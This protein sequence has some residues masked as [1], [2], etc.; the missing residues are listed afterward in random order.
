MRKQLLFPL[1]SLVLLTLAA[2]CV[3]QVADLNP[4]F[5]PVQNTVNAKFVIN[6]AAADQPATKMSAAVVQ[7]NATF[8]GIENATLFTF[9]LRDGDTFRNGE[10]I[11]SASDTATGAFNLSKAFDISAFGEGGAK[12]HKVMELPIPVGTNTMIFYGMAA[13]NGMTDEQVGKTS[14]FYNTT[15]GKIGSFAEPR[16]RP[17]SD[18]AKA[19]F[20]IE[21]IIATVVS[22][23]LITGINGSGVADKYAVPS[24]TLGE[25][26]WNIQG[27]PFHW[28]DYALAVAATPQSPA[29]LKLHGR[30]GI[31]DTDLSQ[32]PTNAERILGEAYVAFTKLYP[33]EIRAGSGE[34]VSIISR[35]LASVLHKAS[36][37]ENMNDAVAAKVVE[38]MSLYV[39]DFCNTTTY[40]WNSISSVL[41]Q[42]E[43][44]YDTPLPYSGGSAYTLQDFPS[45]FNLP[46]G[47]TSMSV[48][49]LDPTDADYNT[50]AIQ[51]ADGSTV[52]K[53]F[54]Y[55]EHIYS[56]GTVLTPVK[57]TNPPF[58][59]QE[60]ISVY[61]ITYSPELCY[62]CNSP[63]RVTNQNG[64]QDKDFPDGVEDWSNKESWPSTIW[65]D[66]A[67]VSAT[68]RGVAL[69]FNIQYGM[70]LM[71]TQLQ[72]HTEDFPLI[73]NAKDLAKAD[74]D[75][76]FTPT[77][78][79]N[80]LLKGI[81]IGGQPSVANWQYLPW[82]N[83]VNECDLPKASDDPTR[84]S[85]YPW[86]FNFNKM[87][88]DRTMNVST[89]ADGTVTS[90]S[91]IPVTGGLSMPTYT[92]VFDNY[93]A[94]KAI[95][96]Q[97]AVYVALEFENNLGS[98]Y[99]YS[100]IIPNHGTFYLLGKLDPTAATGVVQTNPN[101]SVFPA[102]DDAEGNMLVPYYQETSGDH[103]KGQTIPAK[104]VFIADH[105]TK[106]IFTIHHDALQ[107]AFLS[108]PD[109]RATS[110]A[111]GLS[112]DLKWDD[113]FT[114]NV[115]LG[116][117][118]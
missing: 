47:C 58:S 113:G 57:P 25:V 108:V 64:L 28:A 13:R 45:H 77:N 101:E 26:T 102:A 93:D 5:D 94:T 90:S 24:V 97:S 61:D 54:I 18:Q 118:N 50:F 106:V 85:E 67:F 70:A 83:F 68:T 8:R 33:N 29:Y 43:Q 114:Y 73:D 44:K 46:V 75:N 111:L 71:Q 109:L 19:F 12:S 98:F 62:Y 22:Y 41:Y 99:G 27:V 21:N 63:I 88:Y 92:V 40:T 51:V 35:E 116:D 55:N 105:T 66:N 86:T 96:Q 3:D 10:K 16:I 1:F 49:D 53:R 20:E 15:I 117:A 69:N 59:Y 76:T 103:V 60:G 34:A 82:Q 48:V 56:D 91:V 81:L 65:N 72:Y 38:S 39:N 6:I 87:I 17:G 37:P 14:Y 79:A 9:S 104:R 23:I 36:V 11:L 89:S 2:A 7:S 110:L 52:A 115:D 80:L 74:H 84:I 30:T 4:T 107:K 95:D 31:S 78:S 32:Q 100:G 112:V 42:L